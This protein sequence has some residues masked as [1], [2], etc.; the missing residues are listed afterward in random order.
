MSAGSTTT[1]TPCPRGQQL[2][3]HPVR[4]A[5]DYTDTHFS[6][7]SKF[8][9]VTFLVG[10]YFFQRK[11]I[12]CVSARSLT[13]RTHI[14]CEYLCD[15]K[16]VCGTIFACSYGGPGR[17][18]EQQ[19]NGRDAVPL[20]IRIVS[21]I[22]CMGFRSSIRKAYFLGCC[23]YICVMGTL[24]TFEITEILHLDK[25]IFN[26]NPHGMFYNLF[27]MTSK[28]YMPFEALPPSPLPHNGGIV[29]T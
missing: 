6:K 8:I 4:V 1:P 29:I 28:S 16:K 9:F 5:N 25:S 7:I 10:F 18:F 24:K 26:P 14:F 21:Y 22:C 12:S 3:R 2:R 15:N 23:C 13:M 19:K 11:I 20:N 17:I 27:R